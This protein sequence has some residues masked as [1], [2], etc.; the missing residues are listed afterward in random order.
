MEVRASTLAG[1]RKSDFGDLEPLSVTDR[2]WSCTK[3]CLPLFTVTIVVPAL[4]GSVALF[5]TIVTSS[6]ELPGLYGIYMHGHWSL[7]FVCCWAWSLIAKLPGM[8]GL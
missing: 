4:R 6:L 2:S 3:F 5:A 8:W 1:Q 7:S